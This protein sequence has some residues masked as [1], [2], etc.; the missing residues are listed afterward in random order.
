MADI[1]SRM[2][3]VRAR[4]RQVRGYRWPL[5][6]LEGLDLIKECHDALV[7]AAEYFGVER[8]DSMLTL[9]MAHVLF[10]ESGRG[11]QVKDWTRVQLYHLGKAYWCLKTENWRLGDGKIAKLICREQ[12]ERFGENPELV[13]KQLAQAKLMFFRE[14][15]PDKEE[16]NA[17]IEKIRLAFER[18][19]K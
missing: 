6:G 10:G 19:R 8:K 14:I 18:V 12:A 4:Y 3:T 2:D 13:R 11:R 16:D 5:G 15:S 1:K 7:R 9:L 17:L